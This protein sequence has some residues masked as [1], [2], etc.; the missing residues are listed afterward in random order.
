MSILAKAT[1]VKT[2]DN[3]QT[4]GGDD[5]DDIGDEKHFHL[6]LSGRQGC[7]HHAGRVSHESEHCPVCRLSENCIYNNW[8]VQE[9]YE[10]PVIFLKLPTCPGSTSSSVAPWVARTAAAIASITFDDL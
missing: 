6:H 5:E 3:H 1:F 10:Q 9:R 2:E 7:L 4:G 8:E